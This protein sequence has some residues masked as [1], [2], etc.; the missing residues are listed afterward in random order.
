MGATKSSLNQTNAATGPARKNTEMP[1]CLKT[2]KITL[3]NDAGHHAGRGRGATGAS[4]GSEN[5]GNFVHGRQINAEASN[6]QLVSAFAR[7][8]K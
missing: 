6:I 8:S 2:K 4:N 3:S 5:A 7:F 1:G